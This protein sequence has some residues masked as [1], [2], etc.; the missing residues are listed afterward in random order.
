MC[1]P[2][3]TSPDSH[4]LQSEVSADSAMISSLALRTIVAAFGDFL[5]LLDGLYY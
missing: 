4:D 5:Y 2:I 3:S 1:F